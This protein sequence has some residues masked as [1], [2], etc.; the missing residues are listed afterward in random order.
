[1]TLELLRE[2]F[3]Q[4]LPGET[5]HQEFLPMRGSSKAAI[6]SGAPYRNASVAIILHCNQQGKLATIVTQR[7]VYDGNHSGQISFPGGKHDEKDA[8][9]LQTAIRECIEEIGI[10]CTNF[11]YLGSLTSLY[12][13]VSEFLIQPYVFYAKDNTFQFA[14]NE[15]EVAAIKVIDLHAL[16]HPSAQSKEDVIISEQHIIKNVPHFNQDNIKI[17]G[18]TAL[19]LNELRQMIYNDLVKIENEQNQ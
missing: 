16:F 9:L 1:M 6:A 12:I 2:L 3:Q 5:A 19:L 7:Q 10:D 13:P 4:E 11:E 14:R 18:A 15:R 8:D 17:W